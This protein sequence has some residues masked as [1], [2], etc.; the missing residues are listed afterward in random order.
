LIKDGEEILPSFWSDNYFS[1]PGHGT[2]TVT[3]TCPTAVT[4]QSGE[5]MLDGSGSTADRMPALRLDGWN[6][7]EKEMGLNGN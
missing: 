6:L 3:V 1:I 7:S 5:V 2:V 4:R